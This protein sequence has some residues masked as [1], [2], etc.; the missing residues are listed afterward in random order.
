LSG[1]ASGAIG[2]LGAAGPVGAAIAAVV[3]LPDV[4]RGIDDTIGGLV[5][6][7]E[8]LPAALTTALE[9]TVPAILESI[10]QLVSA[11]LQAAIEIP[12]IVLEA[13]PEIVAGLVGMLPDLIS[14]LVDAVVKLGQ[15]VLSSMLS[16]GLFVAI[17]EGVWNA[18]NDMLNGVPQKIAE[19]I[20]R[21][22]EPLLKPFRD[23]EGR[24]LGTDLRA[25]GGRSLF[26]IELPSFA[27]GTSEITRTGVAVVHRGEEIRRPGQARTGGAAPVI[28]VHGATDV[29]EVV[30]QVRAVLGGDYGP[31]YGTGEVLP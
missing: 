5:G 31:S 22:F 19:A 21:V 11:V 4:L 12:G 7:F 3:T 16:G 9:E 2:G 14:G 15:E 26:G 30:R 10:P 28:H 18:L 25:E 13:I 29:R 20:L 6:M 23:K 1:G 8:D 24:F 17:G 27:R